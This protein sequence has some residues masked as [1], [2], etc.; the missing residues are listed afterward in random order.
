[1]NA[2]YRLVR[3]ADSPRLTPNDEQARALEHRQGGLLLLGGSRTGKTR[4]LIEAALQALERAVPRVWFISSNRA[5]GRSLRS[6]LAA[7]YP[8]AMSR[9]TISTGHA[10][11]GQLLAQA[12]PDQEQPVLLTAARQD[13]FVRDL[14]AGAPPRRWPKRFEPALGT[15]VFAS[16]LREAMTSLQ[17]LDITASAVMAAAGAA[18]RPDWLAL[19][20]C[21]QEYLD[22]LALSGSI[23]YPEMLRMARQALQNPDFLAQINPRASWVL[24]DD[25]D[26]IDPQVA[27]LI[28]ELICGGTCWMAAINPDAQVNGFRGSRSRSALD[29]ARSWNHDQPPSVVSLTA[30]YRQAEAIV[31]GLISLRGQLP[32]PSGLAAAA[33][34]TYRAPVGDSVGSAKR[35]R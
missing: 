21:L 19:G 28:G 25:F 11:A 3:P 27:E 15:R 24:V 14:L 9:L 1:M 5:A 17:R 4:T 31:D 6:L 34:L 35:R 33:G 20:S 8:D 2:A 10:L 26:D 13:Q 7:S 30:T 22:V 18:A 12:Y 16:D 29:L 23:D 32:L